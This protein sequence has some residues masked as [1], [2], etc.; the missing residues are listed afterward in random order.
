[1]ESKW[2]FLMIAHL[3][4]LPSRNDYVR[5]S[6]WSSIAT[7][8]RRVQADNSTSLVFSISPYCL[9][10]DLR[11][12]VDNAETHF[13]FV[14]KTREPFLIC[15]GSRISVRHPHW[16]VGPCSVQWKCKNWPC[17]SMSLPAACVSLLVWWTSPDQD[18]CS[19]FLQETVTVCT[20][21]PQAL[22]A[23]WSSFQMSGR[24]T[25]LDLLRATSYQ[26]YLL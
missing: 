4:V 16:S 19:A 15:V 25:D 18:F 7:C 1:M 5:S 26:I 12:S 23:S 2:S 8:L 13:W 3:S 20:L 14:R 21:V 10:W 11:F 22:N 9:L 24:D 6:L 17:I